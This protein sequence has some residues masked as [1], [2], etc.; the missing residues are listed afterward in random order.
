M[1]KRTLVLVLVGMALAALPLSVAAL[2]LDVEAK[3]GA[4]IGMGSTTDTSIT[5]SPL[6]AWDVG[7][8]V[9]LFLFNAG[10]A[11]IGV[12]AGAEY[13]SV[14]VHEKIA[15]GAGPGV[16]VEEDQNLNYIYIPFGLVGSIPVGPVNMVVHAGGFAGYFLGGK[17]TNIKVGG[18]GGFADQTLDTS[19]IEQWEFGLHVAA[20]ADVPLT[21]SISLSPAAQL[22]MGFTDISKTASSTDTVW[23]LTVMVGIKYKAM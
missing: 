13:A 22:D 16:D 14:S 1:R 8:G 15:N 5:G 11:N 6:L 4:G 12:S 21:D 9:D 23:S 19:K 17:V 7:V 18:T 2:G 10:P 3:G 20:G